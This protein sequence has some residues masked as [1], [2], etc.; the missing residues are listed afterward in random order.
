MYDKIKSFFTL[1]EGYLA[2]FVII[3]VAAIIVGLISIGGISG[4]NRDKEYNQKK[5]V[6]SHFTHTTTIKG[7]VKNINFRIINVPGED[8]YKVE[9]E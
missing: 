9:Y 2:A 1:E 5:V 4:T 8:T 3:T 6:V 7:K